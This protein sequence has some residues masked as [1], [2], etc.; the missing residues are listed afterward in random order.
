MADKLAMEK[1]VTG[2]YLSGH[3]MAEYL[4]AYGQ[5]HAAKTGELL[6]EDTGRYHDGDHVT[7]LGILTKVRLKV[8]KNNSTMAFV[9]VEDMFGSIEALVFPNTLTQY[10][11][12]ITEGSVVQ[13]RGR[14]SMR[15]DEETKLVCEQ[16]LP[17]PD[18]GR[19]GDHP[20]PKK[21]KRPGL[22]LKVPS[23]ESPLYEKAKKYILVFDG[24]T[25]LYVY[26][27][28][29][30]KLMLAPTSMRVDVNDVLL[31]ELCKVLGKA[32]VAFVKE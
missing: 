31:R 20:S 12:L 17:A 10:A 28:D 5:L 23:K 14:V 9:T 24:P 26:F 6:D 8:T 11:A 27:E 4:P 15:E 19:I 22:Y 7:L 16:V 32:N 25:P 30:K 2:M 18:K 3:P 1:E 13:M 29:T 21:S